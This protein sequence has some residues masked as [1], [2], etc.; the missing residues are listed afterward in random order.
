MRALNRL[1]AAKVDKSPPGKYSDGGGLWLYKR[2]DGGAQWVLRVTIHK[3]RK[4]MGLGA[5][6]NVSLKEVRLEAE[7]WRAFARQN[8]NPIK[9]RDR[10]RREAAKASNTLESVALE[11]F[12]VRKAELRQDGKAGQWF[13]QLKLYVLPK[14]GRIPVE[15][16]DQRDTKT[17]LAPIWHPKAD[18]AKKAIN[19]LGIVMQ[20]AAAMGLDV[21][22]QA[23]AKAKAL[24]GKQRHIVT[25]I[26][27]L[28]W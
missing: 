13:I 24:L 25:P 2:P 10:Q 11:A 28:P 5:L 9:E 16:I 1:T 23:V 14:L 17:T 15:E 27:A 7:K 4:E 12:E 22:I 19:R 18:T 26:P 8:I 21:D 20:H 3:S 6:Q